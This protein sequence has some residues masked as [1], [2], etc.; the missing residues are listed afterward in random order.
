MII[1]RIAEG[2]GKQDWFVVTLEVLIV[3]LGVYLGIFIGEAQNKRQVQQEVNQSLAVLL[4]QMKADLVQ[5]DEVIV[6]QEENRAHY[7]TA[8]NL[9][10]EDEVDLEALGNTI[11]V[12]YS[13]NR[14]FFP[15]ESAYQSMRDVGSLAQINDQELVLNITVYFDS[16]LERHATNAFS[17]DQ[18]N[19]ELQRGVRD[20]FWDRRLGQFLGDDEMAKA[21][22][23]NGFRNLWGHS[24]YYHSILNDLV[25]PQLEETI[26]AIEGYLDDVAG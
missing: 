18:V 22:L 13:N 3:I 8:M 24:I 7:Q 9:I 6:A 19:G 17:S 1:K 14:T 16:I 20:V 11:Q 4:T 10:A 2:F 25:R 21:R 23:W 15:N 12:S 26:A 5:L